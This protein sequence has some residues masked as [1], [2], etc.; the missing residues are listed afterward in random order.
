M[1]KI[2]FSKEIDIQNNRTAILC[3]KI[4]NRKNQNNVIIVGDFIGRVTLIDSKSYLIFSTINCHIKPIMG[5]DIN[6]NKEH[7]ITVSEDTYVNIWK[8]NQENEP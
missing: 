8:I 1:N 3:C 2:I 4:L 5:M 7:F 6:N